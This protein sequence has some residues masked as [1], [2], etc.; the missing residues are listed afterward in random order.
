MKV[1][2]AISDIVEV[3]KRGGTILLRINAKG[4]P[5]KGRKLPKI[6]RCRV[7]KVRPKDR[8][9][10]QQAYLVVTPINNKEAQRISIG[11]GTEY[12]GFLPKD[13]AR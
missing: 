3:K 10:R 7:L 8:R 1:C 11:G 2:E 4:Y 5:E 9:T 12:K 6:F 13:I